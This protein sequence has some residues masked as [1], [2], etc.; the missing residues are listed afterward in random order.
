MDAHRLDEGPWA[1]ADSWI[2]VVEDPELVVFDDDSYELH[3]RQPGLLR[4]HQ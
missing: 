1:W 2:P 3:Q 4:D